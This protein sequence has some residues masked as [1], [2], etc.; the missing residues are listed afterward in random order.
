MQLTG[1]A[2][3]H[4]SHPEHSSGTMTTSAPWLKIAP[5]CGGQARRQASQ[6]MHSDISMR[7]GGFFHFSLRARPWMRV[8]RADARPDAGGLA[9]IAAVWGVID[10]SVKGWWTYAAMSPDR[11]LTDQGR[12]RR[13]QLLDAAATLF[14]ERGYANTRIIDICNAAGVAKGLFYW[15]FENKDALFADLVR[16]MR[17]RLRQTQG[18]AIDPSADAL[19]RLHQGAEASVRF[20]AEHNSFFALLEVESSDPRVLALR[21]EGNQIHAADTLALITEAQSSGQL[22]DDHDA[23][24]LALGVN[25]AVAHFSHFHRTGQIDLPVDELARFVAD[26]VVRALA[27]EV[28]AL[29]WSAR[30]H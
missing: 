19:T 21:R 15:Y 22:A 17:L 26:W 3:K 12:E 24:L 25:A 11:K 6:L 18:A 8:D 30:T 28:P 14:A 4:L 7:S 27:G 2:G 20:M 1:Q 23:K 5:K 16:T 9:A 29:V 13:Q 10:P